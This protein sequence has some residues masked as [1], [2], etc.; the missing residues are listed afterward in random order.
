LEVDL[1]YLRSLGKQATGGAEKQQKV[2][3]SHYNLRAEQ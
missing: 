2:N 3:H 1:R